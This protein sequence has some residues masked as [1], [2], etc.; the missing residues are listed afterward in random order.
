MNVTLIINKESQYELNIITNI[1]TFKTNK[2]AK[3]CLIV[4]KE[5][6]TKIIGEPKKSKVIYKQKFYSENGL[7]IFSINDFKEDVEKNEHLLKYLKKEFINT[8]YIKD[9]SSDTA[10][11][12]LGVIYVV[13]DANSFTE[14]DV[15]SDYASVR[16]SNNKPINGIIIYN[17]TNENFSHLEKKSKIREMLN[18]TKKISDST[19]IITLPANEAMNTFNS[20]SITYVADNR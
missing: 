4:D 9:R 6:C 14:K 11:S 10:I 16:T 8:I 2:R 15:I 7:N 3:N 13:Y 12:S 1:L 20:K 19:S 18:K 17:Y 5:I